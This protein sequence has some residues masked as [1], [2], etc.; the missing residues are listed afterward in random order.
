MSIESL[1]DQRTQVA[2]AMRLQD[3]LAPYLYQQAGIT[4]RLEGGRIVGFDRVPD[5]HQ[6]LRSDI[7][8]QL[9]QRSQKALRGELEVDPG[10]ERGI[11]QN[12]RLTRQA[13][14]QQVGPGWE[15]S[16]PGIQAMAE[17]GQRAEELRYG[18]RTGQLTLAEQLGLQREQANEARQ[19]RQFQQLGGA[20]GLPGTR[21]AG[22]SNYLSSLSQALGLGQRER[23]GQFQANQ[24]NAQQPSFMSEML[25]I[26]G[27]LS[28]MAVGS[29][30][31]PFGAAVGGQAG[32]SVA[33]LF[34]S[35]RPAPVPMWDNPYLR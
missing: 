29:F 6:A 7:E 8:T 12:L 16:T 24:F 17:Q 35:G 33:G 15:T 19:S 27:P 20:F 25:G 10:L 14:L 5:P 28:G 11:A 21:G 34:G 30:L 23:Q 31:G 2:E 18:A 4:P 26:L 32:K 13:G 9:L 3:L 22:T 1:R